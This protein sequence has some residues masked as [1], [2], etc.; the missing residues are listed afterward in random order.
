MATLYAQMGSCLEVSVSL[1]KQLESEPEEHRNNLFVA[2]VEDQ[3]SR[4]R[5]WASNLGALNTGHSA[6]D[7]RLRDS[8]ANRNAIIRILDMT[9]SI[10][11]ISESYILT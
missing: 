9:R 4:L 6:L 3:A 2:Q 7:H 5:V 1:A 11:R 8:T 10:L